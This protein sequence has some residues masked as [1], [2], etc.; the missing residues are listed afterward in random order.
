MN[1]GNIQEPEN[2]EE[3]DMVYNNHGEIGAERDIYNNTCSHKFSVDELQNVIREKKKDSGY[4]KDFEVKEYFVQGCRLQ[5]YF[6]YTY[7]CCKLHDWVA[8][9][10]DRYNFIFNL[11]LNNLI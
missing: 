6:F 2:K 8:D 10:I 4:Q 3:L 9:C 1:V 11:P 7:F 5:I